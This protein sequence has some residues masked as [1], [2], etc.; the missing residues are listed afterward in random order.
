MPYYTEKQIAQAREMELLTYS[1]VRL[2]Q[3]NRTGKDHG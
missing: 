2:L 1:E 3:S